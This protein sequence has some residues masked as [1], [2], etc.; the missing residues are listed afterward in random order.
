VIAGVLDGPYD[1]LPGSDIQSHPD[2]VAIR[3]GEA[4]RPKTKLVNRTG[5]FKTKGA[6]DRVFIREGADEVRAKVLAELLIA[7]L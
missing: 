3:H 2:D 6:F 5:E 1:E 7:T 4:L